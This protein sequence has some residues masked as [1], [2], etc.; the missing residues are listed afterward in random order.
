[1][2]TRN[3]I[4][5]LIISL[6]TACT[7]QKRRHLNGWNVQWHKNYQGVDKLD[8]AETAF[9]SPNVE[10]NAP[11]IQVEVSGT[12]DTEILIEDNE[13]P[14]SKTDN[15]ISEEVRIDKEDRDNDRPSVDRI[16]SKQDLVSSAL[17]PTKGSTKTV[18]KKD[19]AESDNLSNGDL[20]FSI[21]AL[22][23]FLA[24]LGGAR[25]AK[26]RMQKLTKWAKANPNK[27]RFL[28]AGLQLS[29]GGVSLYSG[30]NL[31]KLGYSISEVPLYGASGLLALGLLSVPFTQKGEKLLLPA[32]LKRRKAAFLSATLASSLLFVGVGNN[33]Q[34]SQSDSVLAHSLEQV[35]QEIFELEAN[36]CSDK[37]IVE[38]PPTVNPKES[39]QKKRNLRKAIGAG[40]AFLLV[41]A[42]ILLLG[43]LCGGIC[44]IIFGIAGEGALWI[45]GGVALS[46]LSVLGMVRIVMLFSRKSQKSA[47]DN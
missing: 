32:R 18:Y 12:A 16:K 39:N 44:L 41:L 19:L 11:E 37:K 31:E 47:K 23:M 15:H 28:I 38:S 8:K 25:L 14:N 1:M 33:I 43:T 30:Y 6:T 36:D 46:A 24:A 22:C 42:F 21:S 26:R 45:I 2:K 13:I 3:L 10:E 29:I 40:L 9:S 27:A 4:F 7:I 5:I 20:L 35:D 17:A 34:Q